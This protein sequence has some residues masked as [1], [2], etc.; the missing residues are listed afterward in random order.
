VYKRQEKEFL[1]IGAKEESIKSMKKGE[2]RKYWEKIDYEVWENYL[3][4]I[5]FKFNKQIT[6]GNIFAKIYSKV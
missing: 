4:S 1:I 3:S 2:I 5:N 6:E